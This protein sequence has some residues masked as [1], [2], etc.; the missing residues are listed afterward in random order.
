MSVNR[1]TVLR[2]GTLATAALAVP[3][4]SGPARAAAAQPDMAK[5]LAAY[6][7]LQVGTGRRSPERDQAVRAL[8]EVATGY[9]AAMRDADQLWADLPVEPGSTYFPKMYY[10]LRTIAVDWA[11]PGSALSAEPELPGRIVTALDT[12]YRLQYNENTSEIGNWYVYEIGVP[13]WVLQILVALGDAVAAADRERLLRPV[14]RFVADPNRRTNKPELVETGANRADKA[15]IAVVSGAMAGDAARIAAGVAAVTDVAGGGAASLVRLVT[16]GDGFHPDGSFLQHDVV[17]YPGHYALVLLQ[18]VAGLA[19]VTAGTAW[20]LPVEVRRRISEAAVDA[21]APFMFAGSMMEPARGRFLSRQGETGHDSGHQLT[22]AA[23]LL[24]RHAP[25]P[26]RATL[27]GLVA[28]WVGSGKW[29]PFLKVVDVQR[30]SGGLQ[31]VGVPEVEYAQQ[32]LAGKPR[33]PARVP[34][35]RVFGQQDRMVHVTTDW[36]AS[37]GL[38]STRICR[39]ESINGMNL[40][41][42]YTGDGMLYVFLPEAQ[43]H[44]SDA[45]WPTVDAHLLPGT[46]EKAGTPPALGSVPVTSRDFAGGARWDERYGVHGLDFV[47]QDGTLSAKKSWFFTP[48]GV[49]CL[50]AG[51]TDASGAAVRTTIE[52]RNLGEGGDP[53]LLADGRPTTVELGS[54][55]TLRRPRWLHLAGTGGYLV[56]DDATVSVLREDRTGAW[57]DIDTGANT[58]GTST[59][60]TRRYQKIVLEHGARPAGASYAYVVLPGASVVRTI[61]SA[62]QWRV[63]ANT[64]TVQATRLWNGTLLANFFGAGAVDEL[65][66]SGPASVA[67]GVT[68]RG[69]RLAVADPTQRQDRIRVTVRRRTVDVPVGG[70]L[71]ATT[72]LTLGS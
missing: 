46:T 48:S 59:P 21:C 38:S 52:N 14:L 2:G 29:A 36:S 47:S 37:L 30:F 67:L 61:A 58:A 69:L 51:I 62:A 56:L 17:P 35:H 10:R 65:S 18:A 31:P 16:A 11:T 49:L 43:G 39:Y 33:R 34:V 60:Y 20:E 22:A 28:D 64:E 1:R 40:H 63:R 4:V 6:R 42:W 53:A 68:G 19:E 15:L 44:Y 57:R 54:A 5:I 8:D 66:V 71:G 27:A 26:V 24:A 12:L 72:V 45:Y 3:A 25:E 7:A 23:V 70:M 41:G 9:L 55:A 50:G 13:Y 32:L